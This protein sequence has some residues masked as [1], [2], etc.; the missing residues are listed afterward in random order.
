MKIDRSYPYSDKSVKDIFSNISDLLI[1]YRQ[2]AKN[3]VKLFPKKPGDILSQ[4]DFSIPESGIGHQEI[5]DL[6]R[7]QLLP[8]S[9]HLDSPHYMGHQVS[10][11]LPLAGFADG[12]SSFMNQGMAIWEMA[13]YGTIMEKKVIEWMLSKIG[14]KYGDGTLTS[15]GS[16]ANLTG[17]I[18]M[19][20]QTYYSIPEDERK[21]AVII[22]SEHNHYSVSR[23]LQIIG[24]HSTQIIAIPINSRFQMDRMELNNTTRT[25]IKNG[26]K[27][28]GVIANAGSTPV[29]AF[30]PFLDIGEICEKN[31]AWFHVDGAHGA[32]Y[33]LLP[34][35]KGKLAGI[36]RADSMVWDPHK[37][38]FM[39]LVIGSI[40]FREK[41][42][43][44]ATFHQH[45]PYIFNAVD[46]QEQ[47]F[48]IGEH[49][50]QCSRR[51]DSLKLFLCLKAYGE[52]WFRET[53]EYLNDLTQQF[54]LALNHESEIK[55]PIEPEAN[56]LVWTFLQHDGQ[57]DQERNR[58]IKHHLNSSGEFYITS[59]VIHSIYYLRVTIINPL[60]EM[61][62]LK[63]LIQRMK[64]IN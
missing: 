13:P 62:H 32:S 43:L 60:T 39:P 29:G 41:E 4:F 35:F 63:L 1:E 2:S 22:C 54:Y 56:I 58:R 26:K 19:R 49:T 9:Q 18:A 3:K 40:L 61:T 20:N 12:I 34:S 33:L 45:A 59:T 42:K 10:H 23:A 15:G 14:W 27:V 48:N 37:L 64:D 16:A 57:P 38:L 17:L 46:P 52:S 50:I 7:D 21:Q 6:F 36:E 55:S 51:N 28:I 31:Q 30:D 53:L 11:P 47:E 5:I 8:L 24:F 25:L 44:N